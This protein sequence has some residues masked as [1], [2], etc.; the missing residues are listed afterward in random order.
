LNPIKGS[1]QGGT[2]PCVIIQNNLGNKHSSVT[3]IA[4]ITSSN[5]EHKNYP[6]N[7]FVTAKETGLD[8][9]SIVMLNQLRTNA[10]TRL[11]KKIGTI[12]ETKMLEIDLALKISLYP[13]YKQLTNT[14]NQPTSSNKPKLIS[15]PPTF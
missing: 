14:I 4:C 8:H 5:L 15:P 13:P 9:D 12:S 1:E 11:I 10:K 6:T 3:I 7:V 2:R